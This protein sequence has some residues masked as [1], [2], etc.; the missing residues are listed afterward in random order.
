MLAV[1]PTGIGCLGLMSATAAIDE[2]GNAAITSRISAPSVGKALSTKPRFVI[3][4]ASALMRPAKIFDSAPVA[5]SAGRSS[6]ECGWQASVS[7]FFIQPLRHLFSGPELPPDPHW[8][9]IREAVARE[10]KKLR[11]LPGEA[12]QH[13]YLRTV[14]DEIVSRIKT[15]CRTERI[16]FHYNLHGGRKEQYLEKGGILA[17][18]GDIRSHVT[19]APK[20]SLHHKIFFFDSNDSNLFEILD[21]PNPHIVFFSSRMGD[22]LIPFRLDSLYLQRILAAKHAF[23]LNSLSVSFDEDWLNTKGM[24]G[25]PSSTFLTPPLTAFKQVPSAWACPGSLV[26]R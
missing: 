23:D 9:R 4:A 14:G 17:T 6:A 24:I 21:E 18:M 11:S 5:A 20:T 1:G 8:E 10:I 26:M 3:P 13:A 19:N 7:K 15:H 16:G 2:T 22:I 25:I 12:E